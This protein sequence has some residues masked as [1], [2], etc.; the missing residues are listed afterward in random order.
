MK[1][2]D[3]KKLDYIVKPIVMEP[4]SSYPMQLK[5]LIPEKQ[6]MKR[7][8]N[9]Y[10]GRVKERNIENQ[11]NAAIYSGIALVQVAL[12]LALKTPHIIPHVI[13]MGTCYAAAS[14]TGRP[15]VLGTIDTF[16][17][18]NFNSKATHAKNVLQPTL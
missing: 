14:K 7:A 10:I 12:C 6:T 2:Q 16:T 17:G 15:Y 18:T 4:T 9:N 11:S 3:K 8:A 1:P 5:P 13:A